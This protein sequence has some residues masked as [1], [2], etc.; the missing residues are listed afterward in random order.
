M[1]R[2]SY[3]SVQLSNEAREVVV[4]KALWQKFSRKFRHVPDDEGVASFTPGNDG[5]SRR[6]VHHVVR[7]AQKRRRRIRNRG[8]SILM[9]SV[10]ISSKIKI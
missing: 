9:N 4:L 10:H 2:E 8:G 1:K 3:I 6:I 5:V 7:L